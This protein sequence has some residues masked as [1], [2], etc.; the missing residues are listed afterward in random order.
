MASVLEY[1]QTVDPEGMMA[2]WLKEI[3]ALPDGK[4]AAGLSRLY[5][6]RDMGYTALE[7]DAFID[8]LKLSNPANY[9]SLKRTNHRNF[10]VNYRAG[11]TAGSSPKKQKQAKGEKIVLSRFE[12]L[13]ESFYTLSAPRYFPCLD[14]QPLV[15]EWKDG[16]RFLT[17]REKA[18]AHRGANKQGFNLYRANIVVID[19]DSSEYIEFFERYRNATFCGWKIKPDGTLSAHLFFTTDRLVRRVLG[20]SE[21]G[22]GIDLLGNSANYSVA[23]DNAKAYNDLEPAP[24]TQD[25]ID[26]FFGVQEQPFFN[27]PKGAA[28]VDAEQ[29]AEIIR[30]GLSD[31][32]IFAGGGAGKTWAIAKALKGMRQIQLP[33]VMRQMPVQAKPKNT[34]ESIYPISWDDCIGDS[35]PMLNH[36]NAL[37]CL[38]GQQ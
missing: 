8:R 14:K 30:Y 35:P 34:G 2:K 18:A 22:I 1:R 6:L 31:S 10:G 9:E 26:D 4:N 12:E 7:I 25:I 16:S 13:G 19:I 11:Q 17:S 5:P 27:I 29:T 38:C 32:A 33:F 36:K 28:E 23:F 15:K 20:K 21:F 3:N 24:L 37:L